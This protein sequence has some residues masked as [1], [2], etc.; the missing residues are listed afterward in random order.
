M[1]NFGK[2]LKER[3]ESGS[4]LSPES[5]LLTEDALVR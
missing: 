4:S 3:S 5:E 2:G 1:A